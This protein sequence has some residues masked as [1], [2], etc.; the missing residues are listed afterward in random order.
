MYAFVEDDKVH[1]VGKTAMPLEGRLYLYRRACRTSARET[2][3]HEQL[4]ARLRQV[5]SID[6]Y[7]FTGDPQ[8]LHGAFAIN[9]VDGLVD[10]IVSALMPAWN[11][12][13]F[14][15]AG[16]VSDSQSV[17]IALMLRA[18]C[19]DN[20]FF[21]IPAGDL[22][23]HFGPNGQ[24]V[25]I[26]IGDE[27]E[28][29]TSVVNRTSNLS[30]ACRFYGGARLKRWFHGMPAGTYLQL[31]VLSPDRLHLTHAAELSEAR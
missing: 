5:P 14:E 28:P 15:A 18:S 3:C 19:R 4:V 7:V 31:D 22:N 21:N 29:L 25:Q 17:R 2:R 9:L 11:R 16:T 6:I 20:G 27:T 10:S 13:S 26:W 30:G 1:Y 23:R 8:P 12:A 24:R